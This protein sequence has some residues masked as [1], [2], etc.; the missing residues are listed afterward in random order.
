[1]KVIKKILGQ[2]RVKIHEQDDLS[3]LLTEIDEAKLALNYAQQNLN[4]AEEYFI[5]AAAKE[6]EFSKSR[7][8]ALLRKYKEERAKQEQA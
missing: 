2:K 8:N 7:L 4:Y 6:V 3:R 1:M 5:D